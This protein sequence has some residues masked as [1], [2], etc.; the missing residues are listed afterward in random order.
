MAPHPGTRAL[1]WLIVLAAIPI[2]GWYF[3]DQSTLQVD[4]PIA[5]EP[6]AE[7]AAPPTDTGPRHP[8]RLPALESGPD[9][10]SVPLPSLDDSDAYFLLDVAT[11]F[12]TDVEVLLLRDGIIDRL[13]ATV[14]NL[15]RSQIPQKI[16]PVGTLTTTFIDGSENY[17]RYNTLVAHIATAD[18]DA[19]VDMYRRYY[20]L[21]QQSYERLG[22]PNAYFNDRLVDVIDHL[23][24]TPELSSMPRLVRPNVLYE[25]ADPEL[26]SLSSG[27]KLL[28]RIGSDH[29]ASI[30][31]VLRQLR[32][33]IAS[34]Q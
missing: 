5:E 3:R 25:Y 20:P 12:G 33:L 2:A 32:S 26:E 11:V 10:E 21:F 14:D 30:K 28:L 31:Q 18:I 9:R 24:D 23:L 4:V 8:I 17:Q 19:M 1:F 22:Y 29:A 16:R 6:V 13:V 15:Q 34:A 7:S 27:Q